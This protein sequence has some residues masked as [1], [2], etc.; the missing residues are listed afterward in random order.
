[1]AKSRTP[2]S[3]KSTIPAELARLTGKAMTEYAAE[4]ARMDATPHDLLALA[5]RLRGAC[6][7]SDVR[8]IPLLQEIGALAI[9]L[10]WLAEIKF[11]GD[12][13][14]IPFDD[15]SKSRYAIEQQEKADA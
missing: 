15:W 10:K 5:T 8:L 3:S 13:P 9:N 12:Q 14:P 4:T 1:M 6:E 2:I 11:D 7:G